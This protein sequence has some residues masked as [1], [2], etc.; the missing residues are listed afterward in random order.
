MLHY[1][2]S[3]LIWQS[4]STQQVRPLDQGGSHPRRIRCQHCR[5]LHETD[6]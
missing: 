4:R 1:C 2:Y 6:R 5:L 3:R